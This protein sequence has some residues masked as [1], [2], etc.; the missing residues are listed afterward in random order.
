[1]YEDI[2]FFLPMTQFK[3]LEKFGENLHYIYIRGNLKVLSENSLFIYC[4][5]SL[6]NCLSKNFIF[7]SSTIITFTII[8]Q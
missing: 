7:F 3:D 8:S 5:I 6:T 4:I 2:I 1:M